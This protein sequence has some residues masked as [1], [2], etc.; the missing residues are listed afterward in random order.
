MKHYLSITFTIFI[1]IHNPIY[2]QQ[3]I[4]YADIVDQ[5]I[6]GVVNIRTTSTNNNPLTYKLNPYAFFL[7]GKPPINSQ[8]KS[9]GSGILFD[10]TG[11]II[12]NYHVISN[13]NVIEVL[14]SNSKRKIIASLVGFDTKTDIA[15]LKISAKSNLPKDVYPL[16]FGDSD[17]IKVGDLVLAIGNPFGYS[18]TV[19]SGIISAKGRVLGTGPYDNFLQT[20]A[21]IQPGNSGGPLIDIRGRV[22]GVN[23]A[24]VEVAQGIGFAIPSNLASKIA[25]QIIKY[26]KVIR[27]WIG[28]VGKNILADDDI[29][30]IKDPLSAYGVIVTNLI[31]NSPATKAGIQIGDILVSLDNEKIYDINHLQKLLFKKSP[32][33]TITMKIYRRNKGFID[34]NIKLEV[35]P[36]SKK[37]PLNKDLF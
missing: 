5:V 13:A 11:H 32:Y 4:S 31:I 28:I 12:T 1:L 14:F 2:S 15:L 18:H 20:D 8:N 23:T 19:T 6:N 35:S 3:L 25:N 27:P 30:G 37:L 26:G 16:E 33:N 10:K 34:L 29:S 9:L 21:S 7:N 24:I 22:I 36:P 17:K